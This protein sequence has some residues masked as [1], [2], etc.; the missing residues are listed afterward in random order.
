MPYRWQL[1]PIAKAPYWLRTLLLPE[2][3]PQPTPV[4]PQGGVW[5]QFTGDSIADAYSARTSWREVLVGW[6]CVRGDGDSDG[7]AWRH[8]TATSQLSATVK[9]G[10]LFSYSPNAPFEI[11][12]AGDPHGYTKFRAYAI[13]HHGGDLSAAARQLRAN[14][15]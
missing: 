8:P 6:T 13:L 12:E 7:S 11:T 10:C 2:V 1:A 9:N 5:D 14:A 4:R 15:A 3:K